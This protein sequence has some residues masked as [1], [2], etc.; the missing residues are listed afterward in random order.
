MANRE[1]YIHRAPTGRCCSADASRQWARHRAGA[2][3]TRLFRHLGGPWERVSRPGD[4]RCTARLEVP[5]ADPAYT[6]RRV[7][8]T[9][10]EERGY[11][12]GYSNEG[13]WPLCHVAHTRPEFRASD[14]EQY[15][16]VNER[17]AEVVVEEAT[18]SDPIV[19]VQDYH[20]ALLPALIRARLPRATVLTFWHIPW[21]NAEVFG[22]LPFGA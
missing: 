11:Y 16:R 2:G 18:S 21:P 13:L 19:L 8:L 20:F 22:D 5:P 15:R 4:G 14:F 17:F 3:V 1:P 12:Y 7:W 9:E 6:L 10:A